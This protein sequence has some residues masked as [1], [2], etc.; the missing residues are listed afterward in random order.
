MRVGEKILALDQS[1]GKF[2]Y[3]DV[4]MFLDRNS[5]ERREFLRLYT[6]S[7]KILT[8]TPAHMIIKG[9][10][11][12]PTESIFAERLRVGDKIL[13]RNKT[14][15][16]MVD[17]VLRIKPILSTGVFAPL[18]A[19]GTV[20]V[21]DVVASCYAIIDSQTIAHLSFAPVRLALNI[22][23]GFYR[24]WQLI[25]KPVAGWSITNEISRESP[26]QGTHWYAD[27]LYNVAK[28][29]IPSHLHE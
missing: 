2:V 7:G 26:N 19:L 28:Y 14:G 1:S 8:L 4:L 27:I 21:D 13:I 23:H 17:T 11:T 12:A 29:I 20:V 3:S 16:L 9:D 25:G 18:T 24:L 6:S 5:E 10:L 15:E 22:K